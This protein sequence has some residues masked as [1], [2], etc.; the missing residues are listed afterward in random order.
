MDI[1]TMSM[2]KVDV[3]KQGAAL[4]RIEKANRNKRSYNKADRWDR[5][6]RH[7]VHGDPLPEDDEQFIKRAT[8]IWGKLINGRSERE[9]VMDMVK[10]GWCK[11]RRGYYLIRDVKRLYSIDPAGAHIAAEKKLMLERCR[12]VYQFAKEQNK[13]RDMVAALKLEKEILESFNENH[14]LD[15]LYDTLEIPTI[16]YTHDATI[17]EEAVTVDVEH[18]DISDE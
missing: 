9:I 16:E 5:I 11:E 2:G 13:P 7:M 3:D 8:I 14:D 6:K 17:L 18:E 4:L 12:E 1:K 10:D 15:N